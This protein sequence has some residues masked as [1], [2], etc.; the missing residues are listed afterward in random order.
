MVFKNILLIVKNGKLLNSH[1]SKLNLMRS[2]VFGHDATNPPTSFHSDNSDIM[3]V[4][5]YYG[6]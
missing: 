4:T 2:I 1:F 3:S 5:F 6:R